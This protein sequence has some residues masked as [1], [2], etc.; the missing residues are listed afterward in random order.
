MK[1]RRLILLVLLVAL[2][3]IPPLD[4]AAAPRPAGFT[5]G[6]AVVNVDG[7][8][9]RG[10]GA[11]SSRQLGTDGYYI[12]DFNRDVSHCA[13]VASGGVANSTDILDDAVVFTVAPALN[14]AVGVAVL[15]YDTILARDSYSSGFHLI[16]T[17]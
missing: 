8:L 16:V 13:F 1:T 11:T 3:A 17:C 9:A 4:A 15:E 5:T 14:D 7:S 2:C 12:V 6:W 10:S